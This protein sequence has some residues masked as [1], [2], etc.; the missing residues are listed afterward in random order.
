VQSGGSTWGLHL[1][2]IS[3]TLGNMIDLVRTETAAY[4]G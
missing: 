3:L 4:L 1:H 2:D